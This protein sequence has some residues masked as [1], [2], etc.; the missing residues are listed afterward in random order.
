[1][2][3]HVLR[4]F[5]SCS[6]LGTEGLHMDYKKQ[7]DINVIVELLQEESSEKV[8]EIL[9]FIENYLKK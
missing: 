5:R 4:E 7:K 3:Y 2:M 1:M 9:I 8:R 6:L